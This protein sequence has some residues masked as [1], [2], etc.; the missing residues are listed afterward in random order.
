[1]RRS[2]PTT[3]ISPTDDK[4]VFYFCLTL[5]FRGIHQPLDVKYADITK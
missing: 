5:Q 3:K 2:P 1:M 4:S